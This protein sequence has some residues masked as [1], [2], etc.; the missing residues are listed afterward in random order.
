MAGFY[1]GKS[2]WDKIAAGMCAFFYNT[3]LF[4]CTN[5]LC[6]YFNLI[7]GGTQFICSLYLLTLIQPSS[8]EVHVQCL[9]LHS[10]GF[11]F[12]RHTKRGFFMTG[13]RHAFVTYTSDH[14]TVLLSTL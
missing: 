11:R 7:V 2:F 3:F 14:R 12:P 10:G 6:V 5:F 9:V 8:L 4:I 1:W 13:S